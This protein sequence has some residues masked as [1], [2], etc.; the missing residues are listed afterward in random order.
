MLI[1]NPFLIGS[2]EVTGEIIGNLISVSGITVGATGGT[3]SV[4]LA[5]TLITPTQMEGNYTLT[6]NLTTLQETGTIEAI[7]TIPVL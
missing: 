4:D 7:L 2:V 5:G 1:N 3:M 6:K